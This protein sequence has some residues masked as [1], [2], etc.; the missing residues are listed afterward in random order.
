MYS[1]NLPYIDY[2]VPI[3]LPCIT[4]LSS[5]SLLLNNNSFLYLPELKLSKSLKAKEKRTLPPISSLFGS[6]E[7]KSDHSSLSCFLN[8]DRSLCVS[9]DSLQQ[10]LDTPFIQ[11][12]TNKTRNN[13]NIRFHTPYEYNLRPFTCSASD[14]KRSFSSES[15]IKRHMR[16]HKL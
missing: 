10:P 4:N 15:N 5:Q 6:N 1:N 12:T 14:C 7:Q 16:L 8:I 11:Q 3:S 2:S 13:M 9:S